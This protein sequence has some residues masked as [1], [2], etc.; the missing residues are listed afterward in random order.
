MGDIRAKYG[1]RDNDVFNFDETGFVMGM[2]SLSMVVTS[3]ERHSKAH[4]A[5]PGNREWVM[6]VQGASGGGW[7]IPPFIIVARRFAL[8]NWFEERDLPSD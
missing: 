1:I 4:M 5:Q 6:V 2:I 3:A 7:A 8:G